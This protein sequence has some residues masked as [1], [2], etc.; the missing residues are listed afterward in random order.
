MKRFWLGSNRLDGEI[1]DFSN[2]DQLEYFMV[3]DNQFIG[4]FPLISPSMILERLDIS[5]NQF[6]GCVPEGFRRIFRTL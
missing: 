6:S 2:W 4:S 5:K 1:P 3:Y